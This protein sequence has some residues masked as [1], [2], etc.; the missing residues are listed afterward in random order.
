MRFE[1]CRECGRHASS[2][3]GF[4]E[5]RFAAAVEAL[6]GSTSRS[7][8][9][10]ISRVLLAARPFRLHELVASPAECRTDTS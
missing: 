10:R 3:D 6:D 4:L 8:I 2:R 9:R 1:E 5:R 7:S